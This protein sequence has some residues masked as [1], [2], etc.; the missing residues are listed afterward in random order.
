[1]HGQLHFVHNGVCI[2]MWTEMCNNWKWVQG[3]S[4]AYQNKMKG[5]SK[6]TTCSY[7]NVFELFQFIPTEREC[8]DPFRRIREETSTAKPPF[9][10]LPGKNYFSIKEYRQFVWS[11]CTMC[12]IF[13]LYTYFQVKL[14]AT[15]RFA[16]ID[17]LGDSK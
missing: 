5:C 3:L 6:S 9:V 2:A 16:N 15:L 12:I 13:R 14:W 4:Q 17:I 11:L 1:M 8:D 10:K 7:S